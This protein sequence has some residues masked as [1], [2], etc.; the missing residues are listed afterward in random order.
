MVPLTPR[1]VATQE[2]W[3]GFRPSGRYGF[4][5]TRG[6]VPGEE[7]KREIIWVE[8]GPRLSSADRRGS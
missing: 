5:C 8:I 2:M 6:D 1:Y 7:V 4:P 3:M